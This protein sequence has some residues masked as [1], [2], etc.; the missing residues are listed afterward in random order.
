MDLAELWNTVQT[1]LQ[2]QMWLV[3]IGA[4]AAFIL[5]MVMVVALLYSGEVQNSEKGPI[6]LVAKSTLS[7]NAFQAL[8]PIITNNLDGKK[9]ICTFYISY[10][11]RRQRPRRKRLH[12]TRLEFKKLTRTP[13]RELH[14]TL[15]GF[16]NPPRHEELQNEMQEAGIFPDAPNLFAER[17]IADQPTNVEQY[18]SREISETRTVAVSAKTLAAI[19]AAHSAFLQEEFAR[20]QKIPRD[21]NGVRHLEG[22]AA[23]LNMP[24]LSEDAHYFVEMKFAIDPIFVLTE[25]PD[26]QVKTTAWLT[27]LTSLFAMFMQL[28]YNGFG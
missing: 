16:W 9:A 6:S 22:K 27:V 3:K 19:G 28:I 14:S 23:Y 10:L 7:D 25:H 12:R 5:L 15:V 8:D 20:V 11:D 4:L 1:V 13:P 24:N 26:G 21:K 18:Y 2:S 17:Q